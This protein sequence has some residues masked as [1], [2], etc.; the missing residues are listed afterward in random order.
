MTF[1]DVLK[2]GLWT[3]IKDCPGRFTLR[4][5]SPILSIAELLGA[6]ASIK[7]AHSPKARDTVWIAS[8][9][10]GGV[11]SY[12]RLDGSWLHTLNTQEGFERKLRQL[13]IDLQEHTT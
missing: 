2:M 10:E 5:A 11:I 1:D 8:L 12:S 3:P 13:E 7:R 6:D 9:E 4:E